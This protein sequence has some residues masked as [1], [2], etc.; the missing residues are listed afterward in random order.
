[1]DK[2]I[3]VIQ[4]ALLNDFDTEGC[5]NRDALASRLAEQ[6]NHLI[7]A[8]FHRLV[9]ILY[10]LDISE[11]KLKKT[12]EENTGKDAGELMA[13]LIIDRQLQKQKMREI[14]RSDHDIPDEE[15]W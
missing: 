6:I 14:Y 15:K 4:Q 13:E 5:E 2:E 7:Q 8:D 1:M 9:A 10:R 3:I 12:L 11:S